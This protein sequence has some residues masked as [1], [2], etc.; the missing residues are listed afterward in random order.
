MAQVDRDAL[1]PEVRRHL[2]ERMAIVAR[3][4]VHQHRDGPELRRH[5]LDG[6][7][8]GRDIADVARDE[9]RHG[10]APRL[11]PVDQRPR[12]RLVDVDEADP[13]TLLGEM[14]DDRGA[15]A[16]AAARDEYGPPREAGIGGE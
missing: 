11:D 7:L 16:G 10:E 9:Q 8:I 12:G 3:G 2:V 6:P 1:I 15:D 13:G 14:L 5:T 4:V